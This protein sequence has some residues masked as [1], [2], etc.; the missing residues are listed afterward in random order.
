MQSHLS[1]ME[2]H[3]YQEYCLTNYEE[4]KGIIESHININGKHPHLNWWW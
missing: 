1:K 2:E 3:L 4:A